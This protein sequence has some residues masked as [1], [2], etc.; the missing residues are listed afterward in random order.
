[1]D[2]KQEFLDRVALSIINGWVS[3]VGYN[4]NANWR[5]LTKKA[6]EIAEMILRERNFQYNIIQ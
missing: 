3:H 6:Y 1:M 2:D 4:E 5:T